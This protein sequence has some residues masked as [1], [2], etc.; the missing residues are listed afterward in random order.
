[1]GFETY[2]M[3]AIFAGHVKIYDIMKKMFEEEK[4]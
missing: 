3:Y 1:M 4:K 2:A